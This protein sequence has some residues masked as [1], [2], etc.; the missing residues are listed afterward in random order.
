MLVAAG[1][2]LGAYAF[3]VDD[4][5]E[6]LNKGCEPKAFDRNGLPTIWARPPGVE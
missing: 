1:I 2:F 6:M 3:R 5:N 4:T